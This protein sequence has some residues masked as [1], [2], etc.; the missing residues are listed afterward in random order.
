MNVSTNVQHRG[1][2]LLIMNGTAR[3]GSEDSEEIMDNLNGMSTRHGSAE[4]LY[5]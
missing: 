4:V 3:V 1:P 2:M 5:T